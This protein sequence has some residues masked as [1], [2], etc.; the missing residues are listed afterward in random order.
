MP[1]RQVE[2]RPSNPSIS[3]TDSPPRGKA[4]GDGNGQR[5]SSCLWLPNRNIG[6]KDEVD[7]QISPLWVTD[8]LSGARFPATDRSVYPE[9]YAPKSQKGAEGVLLGWFPSGPGVWGRFRPL[10]V[11]NI[12]GKEMLPL[13]KL[14]VRRTAGPAT[15]QARQLRRSRI[16]RNWPPCVKTRTV[17]GTRK[18]RK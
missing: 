3:K 14:T 5:H 17:H 18:E 2:T 1:S 12:I 8:F 10:G 13:S 6:P 16:I 7:S 15:S 9:N 11:L 4:P